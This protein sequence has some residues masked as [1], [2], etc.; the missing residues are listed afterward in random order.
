VI[1][2][3]NDRALADVLDQPGSGQRNAARSAATPVV[4]DAVAWARDRLDSL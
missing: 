1:G 4:D 3:S 2:N